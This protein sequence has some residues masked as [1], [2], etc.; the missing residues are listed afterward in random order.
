MIELLREPID[1][2]ARRITKMPAWIGPARGDGYWHIPRSASRY[3]D[4]VSVHTWCGQ[5]LSLGEGREKRLLSETKPD[6]MA[7]GTCLGRHRGFS[8]AD[9]EIFSPRDHFGLPT[10]CPG[11]SDGRRCLACGHRVRYSWRTG[12]SHH[13][14]SV[15]LLERCTP[16]PS[17]GWRNI[18]S[19][20]D[21][22]IC[23]AWSASGDCGWEAGPDMKEIHA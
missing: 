23:I 11:E 6:D 9:G 1:M 15:A 7:C 20:N 17:H 22:L 12:T 14:P 16:C 10:W 21:R 13:R 18:V 5:L 4:R 3:P 2:R 8:R 19:R